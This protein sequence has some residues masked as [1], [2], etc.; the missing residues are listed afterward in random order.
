[1]CTQADSK[2]HPQEC[3]LL[4]V[5]PN[6]RQ[7]KH[8]IAAESMKYGAFVLQNTITTENEGSLVRID[9][10]SEHSVKAENPATPW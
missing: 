6:W 8:L 4:K 5:T 2:T 3:T 9:Q 7:L 10:D 1:M